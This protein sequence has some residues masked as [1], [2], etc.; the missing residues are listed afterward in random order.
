VASA[1]VLGTLAVELL[2]RALATRRAPV[3][4]LGVY[5]GKLAREAQLELP[6]E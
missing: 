3:R 1:D 5:V 4:L 2:E 6:L